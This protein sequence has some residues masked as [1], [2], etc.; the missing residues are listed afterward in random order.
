MLSP[1]AVATRVLPRRRRDDDPPNGATVSTST[2]PLTRRERRAAARA[3]AIPRRHT[4]TAR[5][6]QRGTPSLL[7]LTAI[8]LVAGLALIVLTQLTARPVGDGVTLLP[9]AAAYPAALAEG[10]SLGEADAPVTLDV[11]SDFQCPVCRR[12]AEDVEPALVARYVEPGVLRIVHHDAAILGRGGSGDESVAA[13]IAARVAA[14]AG[15]YWPYHDWL[16]ANQHGENDGHITRERLVAIAARVGLDIA[17]F[18]AALDDPGHRAD[19][20]AETAAARAA[21][22]DATPT[23][24]VGDRVLV[25]LRSIDELGA[26]IE[27]AAGR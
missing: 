13:A 19:V 16:F 11:Y 7:P 3:T 17:A 24:V 22:I 1:T 20:L 15:A 23:L 5:T 26:V 9:P 2:P 14:D 12:Y 4:R 6:R 10:R 18:E 8:A 27:A 25:G 21:G